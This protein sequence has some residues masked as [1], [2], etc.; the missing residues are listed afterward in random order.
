MLLHFSMP[1]PCVLVALLKEESIDHTKC[2]CLY[3][4]TCVRVL[5][6]QGQKFVEFKC[7]AN[8]FRFLQNRRSLD[9]PPFSLCVNLQMR[10]CLDSH[11]FVQEK[12]RNVALPHRISCTLP[13]P[14]ADEGL[15]LKTFHDSNIFTRRLSQKCN[16]YCFILIADTV[17]NSKLCKIGFLDY[18]R[19]SNPGIWNVEVV[20]T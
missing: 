3:K 17:L 18:C 6:S 13:S 8:P 9:S 11:N 10:I 5:R 20:K 19:I 14:L 2:K 12:V 15:G 7:C 4:C 16:L 1:C